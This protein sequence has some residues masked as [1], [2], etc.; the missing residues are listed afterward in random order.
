M[1]DNTFDDDEA[2]RT[3]GRGLGDKKN[4]DLLVE[5]RRHLSARWGHLAAAG[6]ERR[7]EDELRPARNPDAMLRTSW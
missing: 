2:D 1:S 7:H 6:Q 4:Q 3:D 5:A